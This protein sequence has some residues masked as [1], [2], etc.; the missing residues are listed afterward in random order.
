M[1]EYLIRWKKHGPEY[2]QWKNVKSLDE[3]AKDLVK[4]YEETTDTTPKPTTVVTST[5]AKA[6]RDHRDMMMDMRKKQDEE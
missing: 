1:T 4:I 6:L 2:D 3:K 5:M